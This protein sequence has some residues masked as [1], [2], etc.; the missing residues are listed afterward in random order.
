MAAVTYTAWRSLVSG[1]VEGDEYSLDIP[2]ASLERRVAEEKERTE[3]LSGNEET[4]LHRLDVFW[5]CTTA[6]IKEA[7][8]GALRE[9]LDSTAGGEQF[10]F[11]P[12]GSVASPDDPVTVKRRGS[13]YRE[14]RVGRVAR[15]YRVSFEM[16]ESDS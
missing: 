3:S 14:Q 1:H 12:Y 2:L 6:N 11:D 15:V 4:L 9:F 5:S 7:D 8:I 13:G 10:T 16:K